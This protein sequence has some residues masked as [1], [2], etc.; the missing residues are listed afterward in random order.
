MQLPQ[1]D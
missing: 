1:N